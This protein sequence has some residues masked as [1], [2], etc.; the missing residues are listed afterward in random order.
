M[1]SPRA[2]TSFTIY[3]IVPMIICNTTTNIYKVLQ[4]KFLLKHSRAFPKHD[5]SQEDCCK[6]AT[7]CHSKLDSFYSDLRHSVFYHG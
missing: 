2:T 7:A 4:N 5:P 6:N 1:E 3:V